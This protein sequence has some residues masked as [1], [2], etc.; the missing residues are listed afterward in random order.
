MMSERF[1]NIIAGLLLF[2]MMSFI[3]WRLADQFQPET[4]FDIRVRP[5]YTETA[6][7]DLLI[8]KIYYEKGYTELMRILGE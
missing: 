3:T 5:A 2:A 7:E 6:F 4:V 1:V 8:E